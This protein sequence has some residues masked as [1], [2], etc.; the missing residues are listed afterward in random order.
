[1]RADVGLVRPG[2]A[3]ML[4]AAPSAGIGIKYAVVP[5]TCTYSAVS[6]AALFAQGRP[7]VGGGAEKHG[8]AC[9]VRWGPA[10]LVLQPCDD[11]VQ[12]RQ[13]RFGRREKGQVPGVDVR[14]G[15]GPH[16]GRH[17]CGDAI[18]SVFQ[19]DTGG[20]LHAEAGCSQH[21]CRWV[22]L[23]VDDILARNLDGEAAGEP[24][25]GQHGIH[26]GAPS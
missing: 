12:I 4:E 2:L 19:D 17:S 24:G 20:W 8:S 15:D 16:F 11:G 13:D 22:R 25:L 26:V 3:P 23:A 18:G 1:M 7:G 21:V 14:D 6:F 9:R 5:D 10:S